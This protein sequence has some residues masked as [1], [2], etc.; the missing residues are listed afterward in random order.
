MSKCSRPS[1]RSRGFT[2]LELIVVITIIGII[3]TMVTMKV[4]GYIGTAQ[5]TRITTDLKTIYRAAETYYATLGTYPQTLEEL[6]S[7]KGPDG[8]FV[9]S[10]ETDKDPWGN[11]YE[12]TMMDGKPHVRCNGKDGAPGG[13][14]E[15][16]DYEWP[17]TEGAAR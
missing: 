5:K 14:G 17:E 12:Y 2:L 6:K 9:V 1:Q 3:G 11:Q 13:E 10:I 7:G 4:I 16:Q 15:N 8:Q